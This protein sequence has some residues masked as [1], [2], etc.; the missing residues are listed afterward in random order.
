MLENYNKAKKY[1]YKVTPELYKD[2]LHDA[3]LNYYRRTGLNL[4]NQPNTNVIGVIRNQWYEELRKSLY[5]KNGERLPYIITEFDDHRYNPITPEDILVGK[6]TLETVQQRTNQFEKPEIADYVLTLRIE[7]YDNKEIA[8]I[9]NL[10]L[11]Q[12]KRYV[13]NLGKDRPGKVRR[14]S[15]KDIEDIRK[16]HASGQSL[17]QISIKYGCTIQTIWA[18]LKNKSYM[19][20]SPFNSNPLKIK[21]KITR[22]EYEL[23]PEKYEDYEYDIDRNSDFNEFYTQLSHKTENYGLLI[24]ES[25]KLDL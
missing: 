20:D 21:A 15:G 16:L 12:V 1:L 22:K 10:S 18:V 11:H 2:I 24:V 17:N 9:L 13:N 6:E 3:Y 23:H 19:H 5:K 8:E 7:G 25:R 4:F 14:F